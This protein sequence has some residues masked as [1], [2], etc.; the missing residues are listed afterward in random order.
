MAAKDTC[1]ESSPALRS[2]LQ[3]AAFSKG[4]AAFGDLRPFYSDG[5]RPQL[6]HLNFREIRGQH[7]ALRETLKFAYVQLFGSRV[8]DFYVEYLRFSSAVARYFFP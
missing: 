1:L 2:T 7:K 8:R 5:L 4:F 3:L 6:K